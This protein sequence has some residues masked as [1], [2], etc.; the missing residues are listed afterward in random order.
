MKNFAIS[1]QVKFER[2]Q[3]N[4]ARYDKFQSWALTELEKIVPAQASKPQTPRYLPPEQ[5]V[6]KKHIITGNDDIIW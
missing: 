2:G 3:R 6:P 4:R 1:Q 5:G